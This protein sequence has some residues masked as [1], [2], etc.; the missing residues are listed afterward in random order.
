ML[1]I[2]EKPDVAKAIA[3]AIGTN[4]STKDGYMT[5]GKDTITWCFGHMMMLKD[6]EDYDKKYEFWKLEDLPFVFLP[7]QRKNNPKT[8][9]QLKVIKDLVKQADTIVNAGDPDD[10]GQLLVDEILREVNNKKPVNK[11]S[12]MKVGDAGID[13]LTK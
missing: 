1:F 7:Y 9:K 3:K 8:S 5:D 12:K 2:A 6:P 4:F 10:E 11:K 13:C